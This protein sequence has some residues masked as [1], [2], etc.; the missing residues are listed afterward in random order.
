MW[1]S[2]TSSRPRSPPETDPYPERPR[3]R[4]DLKQK[5]KK[6]SVDIPTSSLFRRCTKGRR[7]KSNLAFYRYRNYAAYVKKEKKRIPM[8]IHHPAPV[9][10][11]FRAG[12]KS[13]PKVSLLM[14]RPAVFPIRNDVLAAPE[15]TKFIREKKNRIRDFRRRSPENRTV[16]RRKRKVCRP[17][18]SQ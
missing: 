3:S 5:Q 6:I 7:L 8:E 2:K 1:T 17:P 4:G 16:P 14:K 15:L 18:K 13:A 12:E 10:S 11:K 9:F